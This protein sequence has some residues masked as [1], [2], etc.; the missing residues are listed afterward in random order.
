MA[1][2]RFG[3]DLGIDLNEAVRD[4][5]VHVGIE[6]NEPVGHPV[7]EVYFNKPADS[8]EVQEAAFHLNNPVFSDINEEDSG[9]EENQD[10]AHD[11]LLDLDLNEPAEAQLLPDLNEIPGLVDDG[12]DP[13]VDP[14]QDQGSRSDAVG[15]RITRK[16]YCD[17]T[18]R[19]VYAMLLEGSVSGR[20]PDG[21]SLQVSVAMGVSRR[22]VQRIWNEGQEGGGIHAVVNKRVKNC[23]RK[24]IEL[25]PEAITAISIKDRKTL[26]LARGLGMTK[27]T[28][29]RRLKEGKIERKAFS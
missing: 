9:V 7:S 13:Q 16:Q 12:S 10:E 22:C 20:L 19:G 4:H 3:Q 15:V 24:K 27:S 11:D 6:L 21:L 26:D 14:S 17:D 28:V 2:A 5:D 1:D 23:G 29:F 18:K 25:Q 8:D